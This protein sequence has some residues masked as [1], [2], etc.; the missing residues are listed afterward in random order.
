[1][2][3]SWKGRGRVAVL[4]GALLV[5]TA[6]TPT[7][8]GATT[9]IELDVPDLTLRSDAV[10]RGTV[11]NVQSRWSS[12]GMRIITEIEI[13]VDESMKGEAGQSV[14]V[15][16][17]G[18]EVGDIGQRVDGLASF[19]KGE[20]VVLFLER[21]GT[22]RFQVSGMAQ[23]KY[24]IERTQDKKAAFAVP[25]PLGAVNLVDPL[26]FEPVEPKRPPLDLESLRQQ[27]RK[28]ASQK[29]PAPAKLAPRKTTP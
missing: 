7:R 12:D 25:E 6:L 27:I 18:G 23:G 26:T 29:R 15:V 14:K 28:Y 17:L 21:Q 1:M 16:Q 19:E 13:G 9:M 2:N 20:E 10:I 3:R 22:Q 8:T 5:G 4:L 11:Q 24:R